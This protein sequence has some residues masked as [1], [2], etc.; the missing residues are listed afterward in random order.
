MIERLH[1]RYATAF[2]TGASAGLGKAFAD[3]LL[4]EGV[5]VWGTARDLARLSVFRKKPAF[6]PV[7]LD[8]ADR[9]GAL[10]AY[11]GAA[12]AAG[13]FDLVIH[14]AGYGVF[15]P[16]EEP[17]A[18]VWEAQV[19]AMLTHTLALVHRSYRDLRQ[20]EHGC[21][22]TVSSM[23]VEYPL[24]FMAGYNV[25]KAGLAALSESLLFESRGTA[26][27]V[28]DFRPAD[29]RTG[30]NVSMAAHHPAAKSSVAV[31]RAW[32]ALED[33]LATAPLPVAAARDL[34]RALRR[35]Q[36]GTVR[37]GSLFQATVAP[38]AARLMPEALKRR[39]SARYFGAT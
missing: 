15:A 30:F 18:E 9:A 4:M 19:S 25:A 7:A 3:M 32:R 38:L 31:T 20:R 1:E 2:V 11:E 10:V 26:V 17:D 6:H 37:S 16:F 23:A 14:N 34:R 39:I 13:G 5:Q 22:V 27:R 12:Q 8:L 29:Y 33:N 35:D 21:L 36:T 28:I 24:P